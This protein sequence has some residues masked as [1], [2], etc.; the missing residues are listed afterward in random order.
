MTNDKLELLVQQSYSKS[1][2]EEIFFKE[3]NDILQNASFS[4]IQ[5]AIPVDDLPLIYIIGAPRSG[6][7]LL[8]QLIARH[9]SVGYINNLIAR[10]WQ[11]PSVGIRLSR[12]NFLDQQRHEILLESAYGRSPDIVGPHEFSYFWQD[13][14]DYF[15]E[16]TGTY[17]ARPDEMI[18]KQGLKNVLENEILAV[19]ETATVFKYQRAGFYARLLTHLHPKSLF[20]YIKREEEATVRSIL[21]SRKRIHG[22]YEQWWSLK[23]SRF[24]FENLGKDPVK[25]VVMQVQNIHSDFEKQLSHQDVNVL[26]IHYEELCEAPHQTLSTI[27]GAVNDMGCNL[28]LMGD[29]PDLQVSKTIQNL[30]ENLEQVLKELLQ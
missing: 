28:D 6:T 22:T 3:L 24:P 18:D 15:D 7:T 1:K 25:D 14:L 26:H 9:L 4:P 17:Q 29:I 21:A 8:Y 10:F 30:P 2:S 5:S 19:F 23:P 12:A 16:E 27:S 11:R 13:W 20:I